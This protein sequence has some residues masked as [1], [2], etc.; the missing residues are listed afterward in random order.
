MSKVKKVNIENEARVELHDA[1]LLTGAEISLNTLPA[2]ACVP[3]IHYHK[4]NEEVYGVLSGNG[5]VIVD[6][7]EITLTKGDWIKITPAQKRQFFASE[8]DAITFICLQVKENSLDTYTMSD[9]EVIQ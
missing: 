4:N 8:N 7:E 9:A 5:K 2:G 6:D 3:F 1:L